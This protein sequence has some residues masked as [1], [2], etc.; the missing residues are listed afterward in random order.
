MKLKGVLAGLD[1]ADTDKVP[2]EYRELVKAYFGA[3]SRGDESI[4][5]R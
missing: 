3:L 1:G 4:I 2:E 5:E